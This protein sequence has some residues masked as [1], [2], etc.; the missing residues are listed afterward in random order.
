MQYSTNSSSMK[1]CMTCEYFIGEREATFDKRGVHYPPGGHGEC[2]YKSVRKKTAN[3]GACM[4]YKKWG[5]LK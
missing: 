5:V 4:S 3:N 1:R 2:C